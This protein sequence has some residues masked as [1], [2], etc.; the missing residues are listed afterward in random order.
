MWHHISP[1]IPI[2]YAY[3]FFV[4]FS[5]YLHASM[6]NPGVC[7]HLMPNSKKQLIN[8][9]ILP[10]NLHPQPPI[11]P[12][13]DPLAI[14]PSTSEWVMVLSPVARLGAFEVPTKYCKSC[15][16]WRPPR[17]H[18]CRVCDNCVET[19]DHHCMWLNNCVGRRNYRYFFAFVASGT[20]LGLYLLAASIVHVINYRNYFGLTTTHA[21]R[22]CGSGVPF[23]MF[24]IGI[25][26]FAYPASLWIYHIYLTARGSSTREF[27]NERRFLKKD[28]HRPF[29]QGS[30]WKNMVSVIVRARPPTYLHFRAKYEEGD[31]RFGPRRGK[32]TAPLVPQAQGGGVEMKELPERAPAF[33][34]PTSR[35]L[36]GPVD[37]TPR[38]QANGPAG[39][40]RL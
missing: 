32:R 12:D 3:L 20:L 31:P 28:R 8:S 40:E 38:S 30:W 13:S 2:V 7:L 1:A 14:G 5:S 10:R 33:Q 4:C 25:L 36:N 11:D 21:I 39:A 18:H 27:I 34:G 35:Q 23:A 15:N 26:A 22:Q 19:Q 24:I 6:T 9:Q 16:L 17:C 37:R 29:D